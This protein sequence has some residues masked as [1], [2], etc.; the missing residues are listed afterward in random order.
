MNKLYH[1]ILSICIITLS[2]TGAFAQQNRG[3]VKGKVLTSDNKPADYV[4]VGLKGT[5]HGTMTNENGDYILRAP[6]GDYTLV[7]SSVGVQPTETTVTVVAN[8]T[9][10]VGT[11]NI[12][13]SMSQLSEVNVTGNKA[14][15]TRKS[16]IDAAKIPLTA[17]ENS[18]T[19]STITTELIKEQQVFS[20]DDALRNASGIQKLWDATGR[21]GD[22]GSYFTL[23]GFVVQSSLRNGVAG[24]VTNT[25]DAANTEKVEVIKGPSGT[26]YGSTLPS[27]GGLV[28]RVTKKPFETFGGEITQS[29]GGFD[30]NKLGLVRTSIDINTP[31]T[32]SKDVLFRLNAAF[33][34]RNSFQNY[35]KNNTFTLA[36]S[37]SIKANDK[38]S[39]LVESEIFFG[40]SSSMRPFFFFLNTPN[41]LGVSKVSDLNIDYNQAYVNDDISQRSRSINNFVQANYKISD[42]ITSQTILTSANSFSN[43]AS[44]YFYLVT[45]EAAIDGTTLPNPPGNNNFISVR[46]QSTS[47]S[48]F[49]AIQVQQNF[50]GDF[51]IGQFRNRF[52]VGLDYQHVNSNQRY[53]GS[54]YGYAP[55]NSSTFNYGS[56]NR[57]AQLKQ[58]PSVFTD[59]NTFPYIY[60]TSTYSAYVSDVFN[61]TEQLLAS[62][63]VRI[64]RFENGG[65]YSLANT[66]TAAPFKQTVFSPKFGL[67]YQ[68]IKEQLSLFA[69]YQNGFINPQPF[70]DVTGTLVNPKPQNANQIEGG[71]KVAL[72]NGKLNGSVSYYNIKLTNM[73]RSLP[74]TS[75]VPNPSVQ[76]GTQKS[77]GF[78]AEFVASPVTGLSVVA[79]FA[80]NNSKITKAA[81]DVGFRPNTAGS[82][83]LGNFYVSYRLPQTAVKGLGIGFGGNYASEN[84]V[85]NSEFSGTFSLPSY[86]VL[87][88]NIF[89]DRA[90]YRL[91]LTANNVGNKRY[92]TGYTTINPQDLRQLVLSA[93]YKF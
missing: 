54:D 82:P 30:F 21:G 13:T 15:F 76:D 81:A 71:V 92:Y 51:N 90:K 80:Y 44:P 20:I 23:R 17:L 52:V 58:I 55:I 57:E 2:A 85:I 43:G 59:A 36:P 48:N 61:I 8:Q 1:F 64:D 66:Q 26:L 33:N 63:G 62:A 70:Q 18:Q 65:S 73:L 34:K 42:K 41:Q 89:Y 16:S 14:R 87:N 22:G 50:N 78:E 86:T 12:N 67:V 45:D 77:E 7:I 75:T 91:G 25:V 83:Y 5:K 84:K 47:N 93:S 24:L 19:Y 9:V 39:F 29:V 49:T 79:G 56:F 28:N 60:K 74:P 53:Y 68:A 40:R 35:G 4:T 31:V 3:T 32:E 10:T 37:L 72:F 6:A 11:L 88:A 27:F 38:L 46:D 69:N